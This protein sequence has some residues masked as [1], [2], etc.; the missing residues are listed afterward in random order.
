MVE[1]LDRQI[2]RTKSALVHE[3][4]QVES[5][6]NV[7]DQEEE[8]KVMLAKIEELNAQAEVAGDEGEVEKA[9]GL[10]EQ[11]KGLQKGIDAIDEQLKK[12][13]KKGGVDKKLVVCDICGVKIEVTLAGQPWAMPQ[14]GAE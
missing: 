14:Q 12:I 6:N 10:M 13:R 3:M 4:R 1:K 9:M 8:K 5:A 11:A 2:A 7:D